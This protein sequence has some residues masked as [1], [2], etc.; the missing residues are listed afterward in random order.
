M[1]SA[2]SLSLLSNYN[3]SVSISRPLQC[4]FGRNAFE[5][6]IEVHG[7]DIFTRASYFKCHAISLF[8]YCPFRFKLAVI[9]FKEWFLI[10]N[11]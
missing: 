3:I 4:V 8:P 7:K 1:N 10:M 6:E 2:L 9:F 5:A 11:L